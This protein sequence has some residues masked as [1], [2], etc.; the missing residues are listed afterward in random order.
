MKGQLNHY[1]YGGDTNWGDEGTF[2]TPK[3][4]F[5]Y[6]K[7]NE[8]KKLGRVRKL[9]NPKQVHSQFWERQV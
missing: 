4:Q 1:G 3:L 8:V 7:H 9:L 6:A 2:E 5:Y